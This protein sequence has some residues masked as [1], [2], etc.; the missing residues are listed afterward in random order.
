MTL[1]AE[2]EP[3]LPYYPKDPEFKKN[4]VLAACF[5]VWLMAKA[6]KRSRILVH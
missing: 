2:E 3:E 1:N 4:L 5:I 6:D